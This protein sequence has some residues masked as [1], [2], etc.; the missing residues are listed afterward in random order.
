M[1]AID[2]R[3]RAAF[4][5]SGFWNAGTPSAIASTPVRATAPDANARSSTIT[6]IPLRTAPPVSSWIAVSL[7]GMAEMS[8]V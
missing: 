7:T 8:P 2:E 3:V 6:L 5:L 1:I 4:L